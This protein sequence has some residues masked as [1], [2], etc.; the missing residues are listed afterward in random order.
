MRSYLSSLIITLMLSASVFAQDEFDFIKKST[1]SG[2]GELHYNVVEPENGKT[3]KTFDFHRFVIFYGFQWNDKW[4]F[5]SEFEVE[6]NVVEGNKGKVA[7]EQAYLNF[8][9]ADYLGFQ[10]GVLLVP[11]GIVNEIHEPPTFF[12]VE[13]P[14]YHSSIIP[15]TW[16]AN[17]VS[18]YGMY[19]GLNYR[20]A[21]MEGMNADGITAKNGIRG[22]RYNGHYGD[23]HNLMFNARLDYTNIPGFMFGA[24]ATFNRARGVNVIPW[25]LLEFHAKYEANNLYSVFEIGNISYSDFDVERSFGYYFDLGYNVASFLDWE[26]K[27]IPFARLSNYNTAASIKTGALDSDGSALTTDKYNQN[28]W[29]VGLS[30]KPIDEIVIKF[31]YAQDKNKASDTKTTF[32]NIGFGYFFY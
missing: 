19:K 15:T 5:K 31:D 8:H 2:Y 4:S 7:L 22:A 24:S 25:N 10:A 11:A 26:T 3:S 16:S 6:H 21:A 29:M 12:G 23:G 30:V 17:G 9:Y 27:V 20:F 18:V 32:W 1:L 13:R 28:R 14:K